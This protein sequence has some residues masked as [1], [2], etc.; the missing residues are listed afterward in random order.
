M[1]QA[2]KGIKALTYCGYILGFP[3]DTPE[4]ILGDIEIIKRELPIDLLEFFCLTPLPGSADHKKLYDAGAWMDPDMN[5]YDLEHVTARHPLMSADDWQRVYRQAWHS[6]YA[7]AHV[8]T[9]FRRAH[10]SG[11]SV[12]KVFALIWKF[13]GSQA[14]EGVHPLQGGYFR[15]KARRDRRP[16]RPIEPAL[17]FYLKRMGELAT[18][19]A[20]FA[21]TAWRYLWMHQRIKRDPAAR[22]WR[23]LALTPVSDGEL[24]ALELF[25]ASPA[26]H[27]AVERAKML[28]KPAPR[29]APAAGPA[30]G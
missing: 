4:R 26:A 11:M 8:E 20:R 18:S 23:D 30:A 2:W 24:G 12:G 27:A 13:Y 1:L 15:R 9:I 25:N 28:R 3:T 10:A 5:N 7:P 21:A 16:G 19:H 17:P 22:E 6:Y 29:P 14:F